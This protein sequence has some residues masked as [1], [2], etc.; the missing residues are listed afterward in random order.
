MN[1][2]H[3]NR[4]YFLMSAAAVAAAPTL[5]SLGYKS[6]NEKLNIAAIGAAG[7]GVKDIAGCAA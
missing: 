2:N 5:K 6:P 7:R 4:R 3:V 1:S